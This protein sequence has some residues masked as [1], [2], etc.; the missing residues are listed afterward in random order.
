MN[1]QND[2][3]NAEDFE[4]LYLAYKAR[5]EAALKDAERYRFIRESAYDSAK[6]ERLNKA[7]RDPQTREEF[8]GAVDAAM[9]Y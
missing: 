5:Y 7:N 1:T 2:A 3:A 4:A 8:D 6:M 9:R